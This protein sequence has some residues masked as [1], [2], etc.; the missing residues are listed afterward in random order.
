[1]SRR[2][3]AALLLA[4]LLSLPATAQQIPQLDESMEVSIINVDVVVTGKDGKRVRGLTIDD[5]EIDENG[6]R[7]PISNFAEYSSSVAEGRVATYAG[8]AEQPPRQP[9]TI[10]IF[11]EVMRLLPH[12]SKPFF[13][14]IRQFLE[15]VAG[16]EDDVSL[17]VWN[18]VTAS[19]L[20]LRDEPEARAVL[21]TIEAEMNGIRPDLIRQEAEYDRAVREFEAQAAAMA[22][23]TGGA[24][25][26]AASSEGTAGTHLA[27]LQEWSK[28]KRRVHAVHSTISAMGGREGKKILLL[29]THRL[30]GVAGAEFSYAAGATL[31]PGAQRHRYGTEGL[32]D[33][34]IANANAHGVTIY[35]LYAPGPGTVI[36]DAASD[37]APPAG[38]AEHT[39][40]N[41]STNLERI[42][43]ATGGLAAYSVGDIVKLMPEIEADVTDYYSLAYRVTS[44]REDRARRITVKVKKPGLRVRSRD[45]YVEKSDDSRMKD[46]LTAALFSTSNESPIGITVHL[47][48]RV[49]RRGRY[50]VPVE[51]RIPINALTTLPQPADKHAGGFSVYFA[52]AADLDELSDFT[53][54]TQPF[55]IRS[56]DMERAQ[57]SHFT[58][59]FDAVVNDEVTSIAVGVI[60]EI[61]K[62]FGVARIEL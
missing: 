54:K 41:E 12:E 10:V 6:K 38:A 14:S 4:L 9:R 39:L 62:S 56:V 22:A 34:L 25:A 35:P 44:K 51:V 40:L 21:E 60:D 23:A 13:A 61:S 32:A 24:P 29:A 19:H 37:W 5:F 20:E 43:R 8:G 2:A 47:G 7:Q 55:E 30:G 50:T 1:M 42:A 45:A 58:Y 57:A 52:T 28:M 3:A 11:L 26:A 33:S 18:P 46:R 59:K 36:P 31:L 48:K 15:N 49:K 17:V 16:P 27:A 53:R